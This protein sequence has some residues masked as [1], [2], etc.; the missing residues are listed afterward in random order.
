MIIVV[1]I[2]ITIVTIATISSAARVSRRRPR[3]AAL[4]RVV[5]EGGAVALVSTLEAEERGAWDDTS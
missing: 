3:L 1:A 2:V 5:E 4:V